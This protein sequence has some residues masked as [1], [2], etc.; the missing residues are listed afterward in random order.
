MSTSPYKSLPTESLHIRILALK[1]SSTLTNAPLAAS[2]FT[3]PFEEAPAFEAMSYT[4]GAPDNPGSI[5]IGSRSYAVR[6]SLYEFL[7][8]IRRKDQVRLLW[9]DGLC[10]DQDDLDEKTSQV[11]DM[12]LIFA[13]ADTV[14]AWVGEHAEESEKLFRPWP[15]LSR[16][17]IPFLLRLVGWPHQLTYAERSERERIWTAFL[18]RPYFSRLWV[19]QELVVAQQVVVHCGDDSINWDDLIYKR[20]RSRN[21]SFARRKLSYS[22][23]SMQKSQSYF[24]GV[25]LTTAPDVNPLF[26]AR[27]EPA[28]VDTAVSIFQRHAESIQG[29]N[30]TRMWYRETFFSEHKNRKVYD[31]YL[32]YIYEWYDLLIDFSHAQCT[33]PRDKIYALRPLFDKYWTGEAEGR[34]LPDYRISLSRLCLDTCAAMTLQRNRNLI[35]KRSAFGIMLRYLGIHKNMDDLIELIDL[36]VHQEHSML[37]ANDYKYLL[38]AIGD[39]VYDRIVPAVQ[40]DE[41][42]GITGLNI[43]EVVEA[44]IDMKH[45]IQR[46]SKIDEHGVVRL[47]RN[48]DRNPFAFVSHLSGLESY[49]S[50]RPQ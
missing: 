39:C 10:I 36:C 15:K 26:Q 22:P 16:H 38:D 35:Q 43:T 18:S 25:A 2:L 48:G 13:R 14:L 6:R 30:V 34:I 8:K 4:W 1:P 37:E 24:D 32:P 20:G 5:R 50:G 45:K 42:S 33:D 3:F 29:L 7:F 44:A 11:K 31:E 17:V 9:V 12:G 47:P 41:Q 46:S 40:T 19:L 49:L 21:I 23:G 27:V 28:P